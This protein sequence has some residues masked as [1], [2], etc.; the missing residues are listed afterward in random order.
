MVNIINNEKETII[1][2]TK[3]SIQYYSTKTI[4]KLRIGTYTLDNLAN[5]SYWAL[6]IGGLR[7]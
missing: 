6:S 3:E 2:I 5:K 1:R 4:I 7:Y